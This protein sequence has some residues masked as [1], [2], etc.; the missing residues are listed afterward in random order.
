MSPSATP[1]GRLNKGKA[2]NECLGSV[3]N[4]TPDFCVEAIHTIAAF[5]MS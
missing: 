5:S 2:G 1:E 4:V 3:I